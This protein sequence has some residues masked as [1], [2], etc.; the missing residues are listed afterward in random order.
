MPRLARLIRPLILS[1]L[2]VSALA[3]AAE[4]ARPRIGLVLGGGGA[5]GA[6]HVGILE[7]LQ[8]NRIPVDC[9]AGTSMGALIAGAW[10]AG[11]SPAAM[12]EALSAVDWGEMFIDNP[13]YAEL[14]QRN[15]LMAR[16]YLPGSESG[17]MTDGVKY[18]TGVVTGQKIKLF[19]NQLVRANQ[20]ERNI[21]DLPLPLSIVATDIG[22]GERVVFRDG[23]LSQAMR[24]SMSVPG[25]LAPVDHQGRKLVDGGLVD[26]L[27]V[28]EVR[29]RCQADVV[30]AVNVGTPLLK[31]EEVGSR[32]FN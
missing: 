13:E 3:Q 31:A 20:G 22:N 24:A 11:M 14:S 16:R 21:E 12:R 15:K 29:E 9:V 30:I 28:A 4:P 5:R 23:P 8:K 6:A 19:L 18:Q 32:N 27:P 1:L 17:V 26:N 7:V 10:A 25:L 2:A